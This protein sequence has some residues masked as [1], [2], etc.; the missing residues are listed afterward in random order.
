MAG[1]S[2]HPI[3]CHASVLYVYLPFPYF[4]YQDLNN[5]I[6]HQFNYQDVTMSKE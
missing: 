4:G 2:S 6:V 5:L 3:H 1:S